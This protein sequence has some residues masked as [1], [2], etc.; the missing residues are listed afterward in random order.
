VSGLGVS[1]AKVCGTLNNF[2][3][4]LGGVTVDAIQAGSTVA[5]TTTHATLGTWCLCVPSGVATTI[6]FTGSGRYGTTTV[7]AG[8]PTACTTTS[9]GTT[10]MK[11]ASG[12]SYLGCCAVDGGVPLPGTLFLTDSLLGAA[13][14]GALG[15]TGTTSSNSWRG[16]LT[17]DSPGCG[18]C[19]P[20]TGISIEYTLR[21]GCN[22]LQMSI[23]STGGILGDCPLAG[24]GT[25]SS[26]TIGWSGTSPPLN[27]TGT[28]SGWAG[29]ACNG[30]TATITVIE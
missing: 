8:T 14:L 22:A 5:S 24:V 15:A 4:A 9:V 27:I 12:Y 21:A 20:Q 10:T 26:R 23:Q 28:V 29:H 6:S 2:C 30:G 17:F 13:T 3:V 11:A 16:S 18:S 7:S 1:P 19:P 25:P